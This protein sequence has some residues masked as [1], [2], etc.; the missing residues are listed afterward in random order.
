MMTSEFQVTGMSC[1]HCEAAVRG[2]VAKI[3]G[4]DVVEV[5][6]QSGR[7]LVS[8]SAALDDADIIAA[9][10]EAGYVATRV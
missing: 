1:G 7:L 9:V 5:S 6:A 2:E 3:A 10:D 4:V 8:S